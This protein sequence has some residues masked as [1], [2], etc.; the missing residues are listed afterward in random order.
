MELYAAEASMNIDNLD[1]E[2][3]DIIMP[4]KPRSTN[5]VVMQSH[6]KSMVK[7]QI[8]ST[9]WGLLHNITS[10]LLK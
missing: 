10:A 5:I 8:L 7:V 9:D 3:I 6:A 1:Q 4:V 2:S